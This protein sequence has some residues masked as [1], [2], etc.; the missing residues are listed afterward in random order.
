MSLQLSRCDS[1]GAPLPLIPTAGDCTDNGGTVVPN[2]F[3]N[4]LSATDGSYSFG[5]LR[6]GVYQVTIQT[7][8]A[9]DSDG[10]FVPGL[11]TGNGVAGETFVFFI[12]GTTDLEQIEFR[13]DN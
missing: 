10:A 5:D 12:D 3:Q 7:A 1:Y 4:V 9:G 8:S 13:V 6:E 2:T 11:T